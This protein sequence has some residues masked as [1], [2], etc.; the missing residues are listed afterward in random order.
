MGYRE[1]NINYGTLNNRYRNLKK[2]IGTVLF[3][4]DLI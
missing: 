3:I 2:K 1:Y 4:E